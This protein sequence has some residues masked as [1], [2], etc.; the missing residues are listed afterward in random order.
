MSKWLREAEINALYLPIKLD[1][2]VAIIPD[3]LEDQL[4][5]II[6]GEG[7]DEEKKKKVYEMV[8]NKVSAATPD[9]II[10]DRVDL[11]SADQDIVDKIVTQLVD[12]GYEQIHA[13]QELGE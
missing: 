4:M 10:I 7:T 13:L 11:T 1:A 2:Q 9:D 12:Q 5:E 6:K 3:Q 8:Q